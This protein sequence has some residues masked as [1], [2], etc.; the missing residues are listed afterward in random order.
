MRRS[1]DQEQVGVTC[2]N[3]HSPREMKPAGYMSLKEAG[4]GL[5]ILAYECETCFRRLYVTSEVPLSRPAG[6][7]ISALDCGDVE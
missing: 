4:A 5:T 6:V 1:L 2:R 3:L 7:D